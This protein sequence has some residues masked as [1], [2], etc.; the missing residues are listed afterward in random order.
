[1]AVAGPKELDISVEGVC[2][3]LS[4][5]SASTLD[6]PDVE[7][8]EIDIDDDE[9]EDSALQSDGGDEGVGCEILGIS[10]VGNVKSDTDENDDKLHGPGDAK[11]PTHVHSFSSP[12]GGLAG[13]ASFVTHAKVRSIRRPPHVFVNR[14]P[15]QFVPISHSHHP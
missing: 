15:H 10:A 12:G 3:L 5:H 4:L 7:H 11:I 14:L 8:G 2:D 9:E 1:M 13:L 6:N